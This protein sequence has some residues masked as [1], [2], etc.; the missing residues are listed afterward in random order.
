MRRAAG[1]SGARAAA[2]LTMS[3]Y[4]L[5]RESLFAAQRAFARDTMLSAQAGRR[6]VQWRCKPDR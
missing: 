6:A 5:A 3:R 1:D 4:R 2:L